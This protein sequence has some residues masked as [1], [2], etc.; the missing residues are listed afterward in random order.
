MGAT[1]DVAPI[2]HL[3]KILKQVNI[4]QLEET[5]QVQFLS[6]YLLFGKLQNTNILKQLKKTFTSYLMIDFR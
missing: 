3:G 6:I 4:L 1:G 5:M 2:Y